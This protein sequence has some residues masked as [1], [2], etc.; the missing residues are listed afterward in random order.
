[1]L[2]VG[3]GHLGSSFV[4]SASQR[5]LLQSRV[6]LSIDRV[7]GN[8]IQYEYELR[9]YLRRTSDQ[10]SAM[11]GGQV[12]ISAA[13]PTIASALR[14]IAICRSV[15]NKLRYSR[16]GKKMAILFVGSCKENL[17]LGLKTINVGN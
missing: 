7:Y 3:I 17:C 6:S 5:H 16:G 14:D 11:E 9:P 4:W 2:G 1:M 13:K 10:I 12:T 8:R 15:R